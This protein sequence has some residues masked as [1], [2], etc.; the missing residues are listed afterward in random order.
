MAAPTK[1][2][3]VDPASPSDSEGSEPTTPP[4]R[5]PQ[6]TAIMTPQ[7]ESKV[8]QIRKRV[9]DMT[10]QDPQS[11]SQSQSQSRPYAISGQHT[12]LLDPTDEADGKKADADQVADDNNRAFDDLEKGVSDHK[13]KLGESAILEKDYVNGE[14]AKR[15]RDDA[16]VDAN[17]RETKRP[18]PPPPPSKEQQSEETNET[19]PPVK[20]PNVRFQVPISYFAYLNEERLPVFCFRDIT[21]WHG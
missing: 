17:P 20:T 13:R 12:I 10:W 15:P 9:E 18:S 16:D 19:S 11:Q 21:I 8:K 7:H 5:S 14:T 4:K 1:K 2:N 3:K 6:L